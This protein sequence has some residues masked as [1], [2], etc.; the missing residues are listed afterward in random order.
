MGGSESK[1]SGELWA[2]RRE[3]WDLLQELRDGEVDP[4]AAEQRVSVLDSLTELVRLE[5]HEAAPEQQGK[6]DSRTATDERKP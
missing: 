2:I 6:R 1:T 4:E 5:G 3:L